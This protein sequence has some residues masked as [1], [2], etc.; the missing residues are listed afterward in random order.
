MAGVREDLETRIFTDEA[1]GRSLWR[2]SRVTG[3]AG[4]SGCGAHACGWQRA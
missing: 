1:G 3:F 4:S 2:R